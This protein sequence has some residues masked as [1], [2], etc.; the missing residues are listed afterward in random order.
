MPLSY[1]IDPAHD[2]TESRYHVVF[3]T[4]S[5]GAAAFVVSSRQELDQL[6]DTSRQ[7]NWTVHLMAAPVR[8]QRVLPLSM[9]KH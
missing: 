1:R 7:M 4:Q 2:W 6:L 9:A 8:R 3:R 5:G